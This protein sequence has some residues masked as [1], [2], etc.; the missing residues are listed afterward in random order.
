LCS[1]FKNT[2]FRAKNFTS[3]R[4]KFSSAPKFN[5]S[6]DK[7]KKLEFERITLI[8]FRAFCPWL[9]KTRAF[10]VILFSTFFFLWT[11]STQNPR[12]KIGLQKNSTRAFFGLNFRGSYVL[13]FIFFQSRGLKTS[14]TSLKNF[15]KKLGTHFHSCENLNNSLCRHAIGLYPSSFWTE[16]SSFFQ[17]R[18][19]VD[20]LST[21]CRH[22][23]RHV[24][25]IFLNILDFF[26][27]KNVD[28]NVDKMSTKCRQNYW[29]F[30]RWTRKSLR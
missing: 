17:I 15:K 10:F 16:K 25:K 14:M 28:K 30:H 9:Q 19:F 24:H 29:T 20:I 7:R 27:I 26:S 2:R 18:T 6:A 8:D 12:C 23:C 1:H 21:F 11:K 4:A 3:L 5:R 13:F 22:W